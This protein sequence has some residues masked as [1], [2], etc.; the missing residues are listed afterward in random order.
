VNSTPGLPV[1]DATAYRRSIALALRWQAGYMET[2]KHRT[3]LPGGERLGRGV[4]NVMGQHGEI[5]RAYYARRLGASD[6]DDS[7]A[8]D[9]ML[10]WLTNGATPFLRPELREHAHDSIRQAYRQADQYGLTGTRRL[11]FFYLYERTRR[12]ASGSLSSQKGV[13]FAPF[14]N[15]DFIRA[16][17][18]YPG[19]DRERNPFH[20]HIVAKHAPEWTE[21][22]Y[23]HDVRPD[24]RH[25]LK[26]KADEAWIAVAEP[27]VR[28]ALA[29]GGDWTLIY[30]ADL[31][32]EHWRAAPDHV[33]IA[34]LLDE[35]LAPDWAGA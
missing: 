15:P 23:A 13:S 7:Q 31:V 17:F 29:R 33:A 10:D 3:F 28:E 5:G 26:S 25:E 8:E 18:A 12:W 24:D 27:T 9:R 4:V 6:L 34:H 21:V 35:A 32:A 19:S 2:S 14:L 30:S 22:P 11:D 20:T 16:V 1:G